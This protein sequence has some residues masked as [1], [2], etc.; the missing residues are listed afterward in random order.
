M[1]I[2]VTNCGS[3]SLK[4]KLFDME[5]G[6]VLA[7]S[8]VNKIGNKAAE[9]KLIFWEKEEFSETAAV[10]SHD[11]ALKLVIKRLTDKECSVLSSLEEIDAVGHRVVHGGTIFKGP[12]LVNK[13][14]KRAIEKLIKLAP[15]HNG[16]ALKGI[17]ACEKLLP[18]VPQ[19]AVFDTAF[20]Q[21]L[22]RHAY[23]YSIPYEFYEKYKI[24][25]FGFHG[26]SHKYVSIRASELLGKPLKKLKLITC[27]LGNG[28]SVCAIKGGKSIDTSMGFTPLEGLTMGTRCGDIDPAIVAFIMEKEQ[29][30]VDEVGDF[31]N[32][33]CGVLG[34]SGISNDFRDIEREAFKGS[35]RAVIALEVFIYDVKRYIGA[36]VG[37]LNG[38]DAL[39][40]TAGLGENSPLVRSQICKNL[41]YLGL[42]ID[43]HK[44]FELREGE[45]I[46][47]KESSKPIMV[48][49]TDE[50]Y[51]VALDTK[52]VLKQPVRSFA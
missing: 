12:A 38:I 42:E 40:F 22:P 6:K 49:P 45:R 9:V 20:H 24:R 7:K 25:K 8:V 3:S 17:K 48:I 32:R 52:Q 15:L 29:M 21:T 43:P 23:L 34:L 46:I 10:E 13:R 27:H 11:K 19:V 37:I 18:D 36:Y 41:S 26:I 14:V 39:I 44:N 28:A 30:T 35:K 50:E 5:S 51:M 1:K 31:L 47:S 33:K 4:C 16:P 2:L